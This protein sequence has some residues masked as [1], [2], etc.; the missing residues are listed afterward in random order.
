MKQMTFELKTAFPELEY[1]FP[2]INRLIIQGN[3]V[4]VSV[5]NIRNSDTYYLRIC[6]Y[7]CKSYSFVKIKR[8]LKDVDSETLK[9]LAEISDA[10]IPYFEA[11]DNGKNVL[12][13]LYPTF[14]SLPNIKMLT[15]PDVS[16]PSLDNLE[17][18]LYL[19]FSFMLRKSFFE[20]N[21]LTKIINIL[22]SKNIYAGMRL[23]SK[24]VRKKETGNCVTHVATHLELLFMYN[25]EDHRAS[26]SIGFGI[27]HSSFEYGENFATKFNY[28]FANSKNIHAKF[29][30][31]PQINNRPCMEFRAFSDL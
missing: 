22:L 15:I 10:D 25:V 23:K 19:H 6:L 3:K 20:L 7:R 5:H 11:V 16:I 14:N 2:I 8:D 31:Y 27:V 13:S 28:F 26:I 30:Y 24:E 18:P 12:I 4:K 21:D 17:E 29:Y 9:T 1:I